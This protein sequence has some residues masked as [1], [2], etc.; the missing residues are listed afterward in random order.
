[1]SNRATILAILDKLQIEYTYFEHTH[2]DT[3]E[4]CAI[5][6]RQ[7][8][9][10]AVHC[11]NLF[12][13]N[14]QGTSHYLLLTQGDK[15][16]R[17]A[18]VSRQMCVSRLSFGKEDKLWE[19]LGTTPGAVTPLGLIFDKEREVTLVMDRDLLNADSIIFHPCENTS[20]VIMKRNDFMDKFLKHA[21]HIPIF[22]T[23][24]NG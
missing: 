4:D 12:L 13:A 15:P 2:A 17:T 20:S 11:K 6:D 16:F 9:I 14:R 23:V 18:D 1:M 8:G 19:Y 10:D 22:V 7:Y 21:G 5:I 24:A 3:M